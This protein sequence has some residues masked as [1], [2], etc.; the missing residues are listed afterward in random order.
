MRTILCLGVTAC[1]ISACTIPEKQL[2]EADAPGA[3][4]ACLGMPLP[5]TADM[6]V[7]IA[8][9]VADPFTG[10]TL[11]GASIEGY[12]VGVP[13]P[14]FT[15]TA[16]ANGAFSHEQGT[17]GVPR[18][19]YLRTTLNGYITTSFYPAVPIVHDYSTNIQLL[20]QQDVATLAQVAQVTI[21]NTK[22]QILVAVVDCN[23]TPLSGATITTTPAGTIRYF[24]DGTPS[25]TAVATDMSGIAFVANVPAGNT[26]LSASASGMSLRS[27]NFDAVA[28]AFIQTDIQ[29]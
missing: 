25:P 16:E 14:I 18:N 29:P 1:T 3:P 8:G 23:G 5:S 7:T 24:V 22:G 11:P 15:A 13:T 26:T 10:S 17:G 21:D 9:T 27:H 28:G 4:F 20:T 2:V 6:Q 19:A 12:L